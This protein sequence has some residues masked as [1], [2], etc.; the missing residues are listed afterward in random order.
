VPGELRAV[1]IGG[2]DALS[3]FGVATPCPLILTVPVATPDHE[4]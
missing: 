1:D 2:R 4:A 3:V